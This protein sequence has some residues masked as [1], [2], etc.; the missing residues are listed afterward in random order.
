MQIVSIYFVILSI[1][2]FIIYYLINYKYRVLFLVFLSCLFISSFS[3]TL[4]L[5]VLAYALINFIIGL[6][7]PDSR[8]KK[9]LFRIGIGINILQIALLKYYDFIIY[10][11]FK[12]FNYQSCLSQ[13]SEIIVPIGISYFTLQGIEYLISVHMKW[14]RPEK[15]VFN[16]ILYIIFYPKFLSG[17]IERSNHFLPQLYIPKLFE[18]ENITAGLKTAL[19]GFFKKVIIANHLATTVNYLHSNT[20]TLGGFFVI[21]AIFI[22]PLYLYFDFS[23]YTD[24]VIGFAKT[25]GINLLPNFNR[26]FLSENMTTFWKRFHIS[27]SSWF[28]DYVFKQV[29]FRFRAI[30]SHA[31]N[32]ALFITWILFGIWH[33]AGW[34]FMVLGLLQALAVYYEF[35]SKKKRIIFFQKLPH[36]I[37]IWAGRIFTYCF[38]AMSLTFL[39]SPDLSAAVKVFSRLKYFDKVTEGKIPLEPLLFGLFFALFIMF[40]EI[41]QNDFEETFKSLQ[42]YWSNHKL[43]KIFVYYSVT[44]L[45][46]SQLSGGSAFIYTIF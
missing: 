29:S 32:I 4:L 5:Y 6:K 12:L 2:S 44:I 17:P 31:A 21:M 13:L 36:F 7:L 40:Y 39:F 3:F 34:N 42:E 23:G 15:R 37:G 35:V 30:K 19:W 11:L 10:P 41:L 18:P 24:I 16:F 25:F 27:L 20:S 38:Y 33:G 45:I 26:P 1:L 14:E 46:L 22:Q 9:T 43:V 8:Y 28:N